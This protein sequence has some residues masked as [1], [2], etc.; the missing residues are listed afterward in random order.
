MIGCQLKLETVSGE[1]YAPEIPVVVSRRESM[2]KIVL[3][4][5]NHMGYLTTHL[6]IKQAFTLF[7]WI[8]SA[9]TVTK[10]VEGCVYIRRRY[11]GILLRVGCL[12]YTSDAAD[13]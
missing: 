9:M 3:V 5:A 7:V 4:W 6:D 8:V 2:M 12:L 13:E 11:Y 10:V 1:G